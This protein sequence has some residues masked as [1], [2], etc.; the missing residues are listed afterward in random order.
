VQQ[1]HQRHAIPP[2]LEARIT[3]IE[4]FFSAFQNR[5]IAANEFPTL[6]ETGKTKI[7]QLLD[8]AEESFGC[9]DPIYAAMVRTELVKH[10]AA[11]EAD[12]T[13]LFAQAWSDLEHKCVCS[14]GGWGR[15]GQGRTAGVVNGCED[16]RIDGARGN[17]DE[18]HRRRIDAI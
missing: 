10:C 8:C 16:P 1:H 12:L 3:E 4:S 7:R 9:F 15:P 6:I 2:E 13:T 14:S 5:S 11:W 17:G 18:I